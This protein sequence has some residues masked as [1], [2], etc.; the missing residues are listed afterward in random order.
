MRSAMILAT[1]IAAAPALAAPAPPAP[2]P[3]GQVYRLAPEEI[4]R[5]ADA[6]PPPFDP[7]FDRSLYDDA[8]QQRD[9]RVHGEVGAFVGSGGARGVFGTA[10]VP[11]GDRGFA[12]FS[13]EDR[14]DDSRGLRR[15]R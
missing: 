9:R 8:R 10:E 13:F 6:P 7:L 15:P 5:L 4:A 12:T 11:L 14:H 3:A 1:L 2:E